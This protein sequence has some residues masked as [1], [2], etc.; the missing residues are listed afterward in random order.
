MKNQT[1]NS[2]FTDLDL[3]EAAQVNGGNFAARQALGLISGIFRNPNNRVLTGLTNASI[4]RW[5][6]F[7]PLTR[8]LFR[9][10]RRR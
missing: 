7:S 2:L 8:R 3:E 6:V 9:T 4:H 10:V 1:N 5:G